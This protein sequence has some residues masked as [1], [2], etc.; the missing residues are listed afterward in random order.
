VQNFPWP[1]GAERIEWY[2]EHNLDSVTSNKACYEYT[3]NP[4][5]WQL[6]IGPYNVQTMPAVLLFSD[7]DCHEDSRRLFPTD[8]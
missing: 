3:T 4:Y 2:C 5:P 8:P 1:W 7:K 6:T